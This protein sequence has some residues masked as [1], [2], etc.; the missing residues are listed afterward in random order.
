MGVTVIRALDLCMRDCTLHPGT[1]IVILSNGKK[2]HILT[3]VAKEAISSA[4]EGDTSTLIR[5][6]KAISAKELANFKSDYIRAP[7]LVVSRDMECATLEQFNNGTFQQWKCNQSILW[8]Y[9]LL[10]LIPNPSSE[11]LD[12]YFSTAD[13]FLCAPCDRSSPAQ[14]IS[15]IK[16]NNHIP[17]AAHALQKNKLFQPCLVIIKSCYFDDRINNL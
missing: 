7:F 13:Y 15:T 16:K 9:K 10:Y 6:N 14:P 5:W 4:S 1:Q 2:I 12:F 17:C 8:N 11:S 3:T